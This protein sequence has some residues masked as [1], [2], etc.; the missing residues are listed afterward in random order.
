MEN[1]LTIYS[2]LKGAIFF[3]VAISFPVDFDV[4]CI[5]P[6]DFIDV[7]DGA[8]GYPVVDLKMPLMYVRDSQD[9]KTRI[10]FILSGNGCISRVGICKN[11]ENM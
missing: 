3:R 11:R 8:G 2:S 7:F 4:I 9:E 10:V 5:A 1:L 6:Y